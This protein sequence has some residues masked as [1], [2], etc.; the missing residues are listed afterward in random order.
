MR[1]LGGISSWFR[2][3]Y[4]GR[5]PSRGKVW[6]PP[7]QRFRPDYRG[8]KHWS[9]DFDGEDA[10]GLDPTIGDGNVLWKLLY[11]IYILF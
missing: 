4:R 11:F 3:D 6:I 8:R 5:K 9:V 1:H 7:E 10:D 2:P